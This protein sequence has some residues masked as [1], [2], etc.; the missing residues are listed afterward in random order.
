MTENI[1]KEIAALRNMNVADLRKRHN[2]L[3]GEPNR[4]G[5]R[6]YLFRRIAW[7]LQAQ[8]EGE[9]SERA[10]RRA[11]ELARDADCSTR[12]LG[13][14]ASVPSRGRNSSIWLAKHFVGKGMSS[15]KPVVPGATAEFVPAIAHLVKDLA[16]SFTLASSDFPFSVSK[17]N[18]RVNWS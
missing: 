15:R 4:S 9:L 16:E 14:K 11:Q 2:E 6:Q 12:S 3:F 8:A 1:K 13:S 17:Q 18:G 10:K 7:R 5:N